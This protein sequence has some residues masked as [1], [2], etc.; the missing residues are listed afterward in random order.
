[1]TFVSFEK[2]AISSVKRIHNSNDA[3]LVS[4]LKL[5]PYKNCETYS[6]GNDLELMQCLQS[7]ADIKG[8]YLRLAG[9]PVLTRSI[10]NEKL[11]QAGYFD[12]PAHYELVRTHLSG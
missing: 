1:M 10:T 3:V 11:V 6:F 5:E 4:V 7:H 12:F 8:I 9:S 2:I